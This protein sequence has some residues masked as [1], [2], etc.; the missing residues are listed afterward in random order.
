MPGS[1]GVRGAPSRPTISQPQPGEHLPPRRTRDAGAPAALT[2][3]ARPAADQ[4]WSAGLDP[5][6]HEDAV[7]VPKPWLT[8]HPGPSLMQITRTLTAKSPPSVVRLEEMRRSTRHHAPS[9]SATGTTGTGHSR[10]VPRRPTGRTEL[11]T[12]I[13]SS[14]S[15]WPGPSPLIRVRTEGSRD[16]GGRTSCRQGG[17]RAGAPASAARPRPSAGVH[18]RRST[19]IRDSSGPSRMEPPSGLLAA[20]RPACSRTRFT[21]DHVGIQGPPRRSR[22]HASRTPTPR[23]IP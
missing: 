2:S 12:A 9:W 21:D 1:T 6:L 23:R 14:P 11:L 3:T 19:V 22:G 18:P 8:G 17:D 7:G 15:A 13:T 5:R 20:R 4:C 16:P 10:S